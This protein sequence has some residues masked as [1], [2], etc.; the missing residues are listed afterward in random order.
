MFGLFLD[1]KYNCLYVKQLKFLSLWK[2][3]VL[4][5]EKKIIM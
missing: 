5:V 3:N 1:Y 2:Q 4:Y